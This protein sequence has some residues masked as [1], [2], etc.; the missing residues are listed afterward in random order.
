MAVS[1]MTLLF[2][3]SVTI[4]ITTCTVLRDFVTFWISMLAGAIY[5]QS[6]W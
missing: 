3:H 5:I 6:L 2:V 4:Q 1:H